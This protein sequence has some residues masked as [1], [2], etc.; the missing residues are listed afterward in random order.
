MATHLTLLMC[1]YL[2][3][4][5]ATKHGIMVSDIK[6][7][8]VANPGFGIF[9]LFPN[10]TSQPP[11]CPGLKSFENMGIAPMVNQPAQGLLES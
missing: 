10:K 8:K 4:G 5:I 1:Q 11:H 7:L 9:P 3:A 2:F 6:F